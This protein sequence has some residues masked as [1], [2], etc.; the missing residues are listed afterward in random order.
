MNSGLY[1]NWFFIALGPMILSMMMAGVLFLQLFFLGV[2]LSANLCSMEL[3]R[4]SYVVVAVYCQS[5]LILLNHLCLVSFYSIYELVYTNTLQLTPQKI[6]LEDPMVL[7][8]Y[9]Y[10]LYYPLSIIIGGLVVGWIARENLRKLVESEEGLNINR[11]GKKM[12][13][14][15]E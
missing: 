12:N 8:S 2:Y 4:N 7:H 6:S 5:V 15:M 1:L 14:N 9:Q 10:M 11:M 13:I 3:F